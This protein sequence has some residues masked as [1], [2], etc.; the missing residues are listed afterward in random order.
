MLVDCFIAET[1]E[2]VVEYGSDEVEVFCAKVV[3]WDCVRPTLEGARPVTAA[4]GTVGAATGTGAGRLGGGTG[5]LCTK[6]RRA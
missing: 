4:A 3:D 2:P 5:V 6:G 1:V